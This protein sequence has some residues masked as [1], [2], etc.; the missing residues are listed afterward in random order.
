MWMV[1]PRV[2]H[3]AKISQGRRKK[4]RARSAPNL[5]NLNF[6]PPPWGKSCVRAWSHLL[7]RRRPSLYTFLFFYLSN[8][9]YYLSIYLPDMDGL[10]DKTV[11][12]LVAV[13]DHRLLLHQDR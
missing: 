4:S 11:E 8:V 1:S 12:G 10:P 6:R 13:S 2:V 5:L 7:D 9:L 3:R